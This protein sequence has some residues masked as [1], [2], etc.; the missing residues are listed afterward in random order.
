MAISGQ[1]IANIATKTFGVGALAL[2]AYDSHEAGKIKAHAYE[3]N[4]KV[5]SLEHHWLADQK[6]ETPS[7][8]T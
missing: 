3:K 1:Q 8:V 5:E 4:H 6:M 2:V 7:T